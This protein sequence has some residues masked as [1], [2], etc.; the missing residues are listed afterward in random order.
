MALYRT[1]QYEHCDLLIYDI[2]NKP[3]FNTIG[4]T[5]HT[6]NISLLLIMGLFTSSK[7][8]CGLKSSHEHET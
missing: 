4:N 2:M 8:K 5:G 6:H 7:Q 1:V 3:V